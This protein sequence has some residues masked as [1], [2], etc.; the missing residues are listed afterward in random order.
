MPS[1]T[2]VDASETRVPRTHFHTHRGGCLGS[3]VDEERCK[4]RY[5]WRHALPREPST[6][7]CPTG[8]CPTALPVSVP[9]V[10]G[11]TLV[12]LK[13]AVLAA[14]TRHHTWTW[15]RGDHPPN[16][17]ISVS[18]GEEING[19]SPSS[20]ERTGRSPPRIREELWGRWHARRT[21]GG[22]AG[23]DGHQRG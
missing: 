9:A 16:L 6:L 12:P 14:S 2:T 21:R 18:G 1:W 4:L 5:V 19:D 17:S 22:G 8:P 20:G 7:E 3:D 13:G 10:L 23:R 15:A 11:A